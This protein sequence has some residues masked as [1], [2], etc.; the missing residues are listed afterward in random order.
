MKNFLLRWF[1]NSVALF[2]VVHIASGISVDSFQA[3]LLAALVLGALNA[4]LRPLILLLTLPLN[5]LSL[6]FFTL[7]INAGMFI[8]AS[9]LVDGF[10]I[11]GFW[12]AFWGALFFS[13]ISSVLNLFIGANTKVKMQSYSSNRATTNRRGNVIDV[14]GKVKE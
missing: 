9:K 7:I 12:D 8:L 2:L 1:V 3:A 10:K 14:E 4:F 13:I 5:F 6:G 11:S